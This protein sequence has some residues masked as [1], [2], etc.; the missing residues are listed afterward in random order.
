MK[1]KRID[2]VNQV[3]INELGRNPSQSEIEQ[4]AHTNKSR[5][6]NTLRQSPE[7]Y[8]VGVGGGGGGGTGTPSKTSPVSLNPVGS[9]QANVVIQPLEPPKRLDPTA[10][11]GLDSALNKEALAALDTTT[12]DAL[13]GMKESASKL[14]GLADSYLKGEIPADVQAQ[15]RR[16]T[17]EKGLASGLGRGQAGQALTARDLG[18]TS[19]DIV[20]QGIQ[21]TNAANA[22]RESMARIAESRRSFDKEYA[23][24]AT[25]LSDVLRRTDLSA[26]Q[27]ELS[28]R[29]F[30]ATS[31]Q[32]LVAMLSDLASERARMQVSLAQSDIEDT[33]VIGGVQQVMDQLQSLL[34]K[35]SIA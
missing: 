9:P 1:Q 34:G 3:F 7:Y 13:S 27:L 24:R 32:Q 4:Y 5:I 26:S 19:L 28:R 12:I 25:E 8:G 21:T 15:V 33:N 35:A 6:T 20:N 14:G 31:N 10:D 23:L 16:I 22:T 29:Q 30:N 17:S 18:L 11:L 2:K